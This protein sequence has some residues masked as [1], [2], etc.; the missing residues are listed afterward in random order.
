MSTRLLSELR[1]GFAALHRMLVRY[2]DRIGA[3]P[4]PQRDALGSAFGMSDGPPVVAVS[5][6]AWIPT[7]ELVIVLLTM[8]NTTP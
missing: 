3:L 8:Y 4:A 6:L 7:A 2:L 1:L 5:E